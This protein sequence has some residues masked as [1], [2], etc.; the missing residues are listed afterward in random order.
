MRGS[1]DNLTD[2]EV[3]IHAETKRGE[4][5]AGAI[6]VS[7]DGEKKSAV[8][9]P[10]S[11]VEFEETSPGIWTVTLPLAMAMEKGLV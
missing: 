6:L 8:W 4:P 1:V 11:A 2:I 7:L 10:K 9:L 5:N 3:H